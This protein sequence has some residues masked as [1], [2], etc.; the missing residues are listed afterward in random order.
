MKLLA[1]S[2]IHVERHGHPTK[3]IDSIKS[4]VDVFVIAGDFV[5]LS[6]SYAGKVIDA[7]CR[8]FPHVIYVLGNHEYYGSNYQEIQDIVAEYDS[9][10]RNLHILDKSTITIDGVT[11]AGATT[12]FGDNP[13]LIFDKK[14]LHDYSQIK[15]LDDWVFRENKNDL[16]FWQ[17]VEADIWISHHAPCSLSVDDRFKGQTFNHFFVEEKLGRII[18][19][20]QPKLH[21]HGHCHSSSDYF[22]DKTRVIA[23]PYG[24]EKLKINP[25]FKEK[26][27]KTY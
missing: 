16:E 25:N 23:N 19:D 20:K 26:V 14:N 10:Y 6:T 22:I 3:F 12:W 27:I 24:Y 1:M 15:D 18:L 21:I 5:P 17:N 9:Q 2:D 13:F 11:F 8:R 7:V 4:K